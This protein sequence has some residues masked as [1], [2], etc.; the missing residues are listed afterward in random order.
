MATSPKRS[1]DS[2][3][4]APTDKRTRSWLDDYVAPHTFTAAECKK[5]VANFPAKPSAEELTS[6]FAVVT[7]KYLKHH[8]YGA[9]RMRLIGSS[10]GSMMV[11]FFKDAKNVDTFKIEV[12]YDEQVGFRF[13]SSL[14]TID[15][16]YFDADYCAIVWERIM[17]ELD[18][19]I[20]KMP[21]ADDMPP[22]LDERDIVFQAQLEQ[23]WAKEMQEVLTVT[24]QSY[25]NEVFKQREKTRAIAQDLDAVQ[26]LQANEESDSEEEQESPPHIERMA[27]TEQSFVVVDEA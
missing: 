16:E 22:L 27:I 10:G 21:E 5:L 26:A 20:E 12:F 18:K 4:E 7:E 17:A 6:I 9:A 25:L 15:P 3:A 24:G 1:R 8:G 19:R 23:K 13:S 2:A 14:E 11:K